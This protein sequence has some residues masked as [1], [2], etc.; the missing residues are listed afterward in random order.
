MPKPYR[1]IKDLFDLAKE[2]A[3]PL[4]VRRQCT[5]HQLAVWLAIRTLLD[6]RPDEPF[7]LRDIGAEANLTALA[8]IGGWI[9]DL[10][11][12]GFLAI[13]GHEDVPNL[14]HPR[15]LYRIPWREIHER[16]TREIET[17]LARLGVRPKRVHVAPQQQALNLPAPVTDRSQAPVIDRLQGPVIHGSQACERSVTG[18]CDPWITGA[19]EGTRAHARAVGQSVS[20]SE[21]KRSALAEP[22]D[23]PGSP[24]PLVPPPPPAGER[25]LEQHPLA[26]VTALGERAGADAPTWALLAAEHDA[27]TA[28]HGWY[29]LGRAI[30]A[31]IVS[32]GG[33]DQVRN[34]YKLTRSILR[35][36]RDRG[37]YGAASMPAAPPHHRPAARAVGAPASPAAREGPRLSNLPIITASWVAPDERARWEGRFRS[38]DGPEAQ[39]RILDAFQTAHPPPPAAD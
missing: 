7:G 2:A 36:W 17:Y 28:G 5:P 32:Q 14:A 23:Q 39:R 24:T 19:I 26:A 6:L 16:N 27:P 22:S 12:M 35:I 1:G 37:T 8:R 31:A 30:D 20:Q 9:D 33:I 34:P 4:V 3:V 11:R 29:W 13:A 38:A 25:P 15:T 10:I 21:G 18:P